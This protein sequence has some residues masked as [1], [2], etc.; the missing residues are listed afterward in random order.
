MKGVII[1]FAILVLCA[2]VSYSFEDLTGYFL[3][4]EV[5]TITLTSSITEKAYLAK[6]KEQE[7]ACVE[8]G[9]SLTIMINT[10]KD[11]AR[12]YLTIHKY[13]SNLR[14]GITNWCKTPQGWLSDRYSESFKCQGIKSI[15][16][17]TSELWSPGVHYIR[18]YDYTIEDYVTEPFEVVK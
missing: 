16:Y 18:L 5:T 13:P 8:A 6:C 15:N 11:G 14:K 4:E 12:D 9:N 2:A 10:G 1:A 3:K 17:K 7:M